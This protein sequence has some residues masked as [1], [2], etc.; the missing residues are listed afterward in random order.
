MKIRF[1]DNFVADL[2][3]GELFRNGKLRRLQDKPFRLLE[4]L[5]ARPARLASYG[6]IEHHLWPDVNVDTRHGIKE[7]AQKLRLALGAGA[8]RLQCLRGRGYRL[9]VSTLA[10]PEE[11]FCTLPQ[12]PNARG[13]VYSRIPLTSDDHVCERV[14]G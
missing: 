6:D 7:A 4:L 10:L 2:E 9:M 14:A 5:L 11:A 13:V 3:T 1:A 8:Y 12:V